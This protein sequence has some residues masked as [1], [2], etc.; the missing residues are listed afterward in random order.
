MLLKVML[1][2]RERMF[3]SLP[4]FDNS[5][6]CNSGSAFHTC[7]RHESFDK[8]LWNEKDSSS[9]RIYSLMLES[10][11]V[12]W[13]HSE[14][15]EVTRSCSSRSSSDLFMTSSAS[16]MLLFAR[17]PSENIKKLNWINPSNLIETVL[18][19]FLLSR[20][21][22]A[23]VGLRFLDDMRRRIFLKLILLPT[24]PKELSDDRSTLAGF[25]LFWFTELNLTGDEMFR[26]NGGFTF[27]VRLGWREFG[28]W[29]RSPGS[30][31]KSTSLS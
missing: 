4:D 9:D 2:I 16:S 3:E 19:D 13:L 1:A 11:S 23:S 30:W 12:S 27:D 31:L 7:S 21:S 15:K 29:L 18:F 20:N 26:C 5:A 14:M 17:N 10:S 6:A 24:L 28:R 22:A 25:A 8:H